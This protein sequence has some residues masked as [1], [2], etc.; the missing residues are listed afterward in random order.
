ML[1]IKIICQWANVKVTPQQLKFNFFKLDEKTTNNQK[2]PFKLIKN[3]EINLNF[4]IEFMKARETW[5]S[6]V[7]EVYPYV[8]SQVISGVESIERNAERFFCVP[9]SQR[10]S[11]RGNWQGAKPF[12]P[13]C[14][15]L[16]IHESVNSC[17]CHFNNGADRILVNSPVHARLFDPV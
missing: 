11:I 5:K 17:E 13:R 7:P 4:K 10:F 1:L 2:L 15:G 12:V 14:S 8:N 3:Y 6:K 9:F 16:H